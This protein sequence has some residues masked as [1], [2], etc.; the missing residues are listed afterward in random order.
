MVRRACPHNILKRGTFLTDRAGSTFV[1]Y[2]DQQSRVVR[3]RGTNTR[4]RKPCSKTGT[5][6]S[7]HR[8]YKSRRQ[9]Y[10]GGWRQ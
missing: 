1:M 8:A 7:S 2:W 4:R 10:D 9:A 3:P 5:L 6:A